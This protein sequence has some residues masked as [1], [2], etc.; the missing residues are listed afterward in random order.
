[1]VGKIEWVFSSVEVVDFWGG[2]LRYNEFWMLKLSF[3]WRKFLYRL[4][5]DLYKSCSVFEE[6]RN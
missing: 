5:E 4:K 1:M 2:S 6:K 3:F